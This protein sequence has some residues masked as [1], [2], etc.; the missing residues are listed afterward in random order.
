MNYVY[1]KSEFSDGIYTTY[2]IPNN[3]I[4]E[5]KLS[6]EK[7]TGQTLQTIVQTEYFY[8]DLVKVYSVCDNKIKELYVKKQTK[9]TYNSKTK[10]LH[11]IYAV[12]PIEEYNFPNLKEYHHIETKEIY[13]Y[14]NVLLVKNNT[15]WTICLKYDNKQQIEKLLEGIIKL[16]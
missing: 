15:N 9:A 11:I 13:K 6:L 2:K 3:K 5:L 8:R 4:D 1:P 7:L 12:D 10:N 14:G 16:I